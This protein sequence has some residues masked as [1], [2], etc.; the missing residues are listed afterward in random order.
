M[1]KLQAIRD[2]A[3]FV[4]GEKIIIA[5]DRFDTLNYAMDIVNPS[6][7]LKLPQDLNADLDA[8]DRIFRKNFTD[9]CRLA[10][11][12]SNIT[13]TILHECGHWATRS[14]MDV[15]E[16]DRMVENAEDQIAYM[17][18]PWERLATEWAICWLQCPVNRQKAKA[19]EKSYFGRDHK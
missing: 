15:V 4:L 3:Q 6:P 16:Y 10:K 1:T 9:R 7:R 12:F 5:R 13:L 11:G 17:D 18:I 14:V 8:S 19:F 2:F